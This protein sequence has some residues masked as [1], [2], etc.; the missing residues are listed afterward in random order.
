MAALRDT[1]KRRPPDREPI[2]RET[3]HRVVASVESKSLFIGGK[4]MGGRIASL[5][6]DEADVAEVVDI[7]NNGEDRPPQA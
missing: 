4:A 6:A 7:P 1:G 2:L 3:W 5:V